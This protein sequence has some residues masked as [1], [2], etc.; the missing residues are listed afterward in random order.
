MSLPS[1]RLVDA[2]TADSLATTALIT[3]RDTCGASPFG[4]CSTGPCSTSGSACPSTTVDGAAGWAA[5]G[6][7][8]PTAAWAADGAWCPTTAVAG[9][10]EDGD[11]EW[12]RASRKIIAACPLK[13]FPVIRAHSIP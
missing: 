13:V 7:W 6:A 2:S 4:S 9:P 3:D 1:C 12:C 5:D 8:C 10:D 11:D